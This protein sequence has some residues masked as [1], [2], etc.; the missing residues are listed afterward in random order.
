MVN[1]GDE[2]FAIER[3]RATSRAAMI[4]GY[5][6]E[7]TTRDVDARIEHAN[8]RRREL[9]SQIIDERVREPATSESPTEIA[10]ADVSS[11]TAI[12]AR[13][14][15]GFFARR[16][17]R[18]DTL[19]D[20]LRSGRGCDIWTWLDPEFENSLGKTTIW[21]PPDVAGQATLG[22]V[23]SRSAVRVRSPAPIKSTTY[24][25]SRDRRLRPCRHYVG[26]SPAQSRKS[27]RRAA[28][29]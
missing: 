6:R 20:T 25:V 21:T 27:Q 29:S 3:A 23:I 14:H 13:F 10:H 26:K 8:A 9:E 15:C 22:F 5:G 24:R 17:P 2:P 4:V 11:G 7:R 28:T 12:R 16:H 18:F 19:S 1:S